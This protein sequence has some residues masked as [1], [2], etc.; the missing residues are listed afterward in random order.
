MWESVHDHV[1]PSDNICSSNFQEFSPGD[2]S[3]PTGKSTSNSVRGSDSRDLSKKVEVTQAVVCA[4]V[5]QRA[6]NNPGI[7]PLLV[8]S[9]RV[10]III[11]LSFKSSLIQDLPQIVGTTPTMSLGIVVKAC[12]VCFTLHKIKCSLILCYLCISLCKYSKIM[13]YFDCCLLRQA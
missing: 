13:N 4:F 12:I 1:T 7:M 5:E 9:P 2:N 10:T 6:A 3:K 11:L 8:M